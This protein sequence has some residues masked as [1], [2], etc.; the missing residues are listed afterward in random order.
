MSDFRRRLEIANKPYDAEIEYLES[1]GYCIVS[2]NTVLT[3]YDNTIYAKFLIKGY[4]SEVGSY[5]NVWGCYGG[6]IYNTYRVI[7]GGN[8]TSIGVYNG[9]RASNGFTGTP[10]A[11][12]TVCNL[13]LNPNNYI[14]NGT[15]KNYVNN[16]QG[17]ENTA[18]FRPFFNW[19]KLRVYY[20]KVM[21]GDSVILDM[22]PVRK[23][24]VGYMYDKVSGQL[25]GNSGTGSFILGPD[26]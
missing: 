5:S 16:N 9:R 8:N 4:T 17:S 22:I 7:R 20:F 3:G 21:K 12:N 25:F 11:L 10:L 2:T 19:T 26:L 18:F 15:T 14:I 23:G 6:E 1:D 13:T 24:Q